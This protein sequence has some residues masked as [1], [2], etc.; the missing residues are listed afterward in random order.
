MRI[1]FSEP[2]AVAYLWIWC[3]TLALAALATRFAPP[4]HRG[5]WNLTNA[6]IDAAA[7]GLALAVSVYVVFLLEIVKLSSPLARRREATRNAA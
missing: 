5:D 4:H 7:G 6:A 2:R 3:G 1:G